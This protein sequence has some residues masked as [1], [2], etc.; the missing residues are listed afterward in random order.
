LLT[1]KLRLRGAL[2]LCGLSGALLALAFP[3]PGW[4]PLAWVALVPWLAA[5]RLGSGWGALLG[6]WLGGFAFFG[7]LCYWLGLFGVSVWFLACAILGLALLLWGMGVR[8]M[9]KLGGPARIIGAA[10]LWCGLEWLRGLG[11]FGFTWGWLGY[12]QSPARW[13]LPVARLTGAIGLSF[14]IVLV[15]AAIAEA[16]LSAG[17]GEPAARPLGR[18]LAVCALVAVLVLG[19][20]KWAARQRLRGAPVI[21]SVVQG[22][23]TG[24]L[25]AEDVNVPLSA[26]QRA[27]TRRIYTELTAQAARARPVLVVWPESVLMGDPDADPE[28]AEWVARSARLAH[29]WLLAGG[30]YLDKRGRQLN[31]AYLYAAS[32]NQVARY[33]KVQLVPFGEYVPWRS[34]L[35]FIE[36]YQVREADFAAGAVHRVLQAGIV[37][38]GP[39]ICFESIFPQI[40]WELTRRG[41]QLLVIITNDAWF[42]RT[43]AAAQ[44]RQIA[45][46]RAVETNRWVLR[47]ASAGISSIISPEGRIVAE[48]GLFQRKVLS[49]EIRIAPADR[50]PSQP[51]RAFAWLM[52]FLSVA[53]LIAPAA[54]P[55][56]RRAGRAAR[57]SI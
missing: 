47:A 34:R 8:W 14:L 21:A 35:P 38:I 56:R 28:V 23:A 36:R 54:L 4:W 48:A 22:S 5:L 32:G 50:R 19:A 12:S 39:M 37:A 11:E 49:H 52:V 31:S 51:G 13:L 20:G 46:L 43:S 53:F 25:R 45:V 41:A 9:G 15:N 16:M 40:S 6:S 27:E 55:R 17:A 1:R 30:P 18:A 10:A 42:G 29:A 33:D 26:Q 57:R 7:V 2:L 24:P 3:R 44:H